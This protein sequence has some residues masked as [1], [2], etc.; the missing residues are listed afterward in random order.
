MMDALSMLQRAPRIAESAVNG[1][2]T[3]GEA[4]AKTDR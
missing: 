2:V 1:E 4:M 3:A